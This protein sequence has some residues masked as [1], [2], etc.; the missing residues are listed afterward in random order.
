MAQ[1]MDLL[2][3]P[4]LGV[5]MMI[6]FL[7][8]VLIISAFAALM[9]QMGLLFKS[10]T[11]HTS[12]RVGAVDGGET[13]KR[14]AWQ[15]PAGQEPVNWQPQNVANAESQ[16]SPSEHPEGDR[17]WFMSTMGLIAWTWAGSLPVMKA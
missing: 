11:R 3:G 2:R 5:I 13:D 17:W 14:V 9:A 1:W 10:T 4:V 8:G 12:Q 15:T 7:A 16:R 6:M